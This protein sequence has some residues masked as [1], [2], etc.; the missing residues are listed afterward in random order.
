MAL[1][2]WSDIKGGTLEKPVAI[3]RGSKI[4]KGDLPGILDSDWNAMLDAGSIRDRPFPAPE[5]YSG[6]ALDFLRDQLAEAQVV[7]PLEEEEAVV[8]LAA[9]EKAEAPP[10]APQEAKS[11]KK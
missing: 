1:Y 9:V 10:Q 4:S 11:A 3:P 5:D 2:A 6:S 8:E 7:S